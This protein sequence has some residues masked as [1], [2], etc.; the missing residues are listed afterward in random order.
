[1]PVFN[2]AS[3]KIRLVKIGLTSR[4]TIVLSVFLLTKI[5]GFSLTTFR[6]LLYIVLPLSCLYITVFVRFIKS[7]LYRYQQKGQKLTAR[8]I[9]FSYYGL[10]ALNVAEILLMCGEAFFSMPDLKNFFLYIV[11]IEFASGIFAGLYIV[12]LF[13]NKGNP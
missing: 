6:E 8:Y 5:G 7:N 11:S 9:N 3:L 2:E 1:M 10:L 12:D 13:S 4:I